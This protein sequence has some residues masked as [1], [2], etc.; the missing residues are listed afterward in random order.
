[1]TVIRPATVCSPCEEHLTQIAIL[2]A[3]I[4]TLRLAL[5]APRT[6]TIPFDRVEQIAAEC[7]QAMVRS[8]QTMSSSRAR[9]ERG[10]ATQR[11]RT[12]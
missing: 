1:M 4:A 7:E 12:R 3:E 2:Q 9:M 6:A 8:Q 11:L 5:S 10:Y